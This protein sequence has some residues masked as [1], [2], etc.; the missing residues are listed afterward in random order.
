MFGTNKDRIYI[1][2]YPSG[3]VNNELKFHVAILLVCKS[4][5]DPN[6]TE[7]VRYHVT[8]RI[9]P[10]GRQVWVF[11]AK[12]TQDCTLSLYGLLLLGKL[13]SEYSRAYVNS[14][15]AAVPIVQ[16]NPNWRCR[17]WVLNAIQVFISLCTILP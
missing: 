13:P 10:G 3:A 6:A 7:T 15:M 4:P 16:D 2:Y 9:S 5:V 1:A 17:H 11:E 8:N 12:I 14:I